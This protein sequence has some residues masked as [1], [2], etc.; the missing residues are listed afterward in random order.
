[1]RVVERLPDQGSQ[2]NSAATPVAGSMS[3]TQQNTPTM[4]QLTTVAATPIRQ[5]NVI[6]RQTITPNSK[7]NTYQLNALNYKNVECRLN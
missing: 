3:I 4:T 5:A 7:S 2:Q 1:M 6:S